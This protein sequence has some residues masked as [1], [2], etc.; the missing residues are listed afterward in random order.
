M[1]MSW[2]SWVVGRMPGAASSI[3]ARGVSARASRGRAGYG[4]I[5]LRRCATFSKEQR[6]TEGALSGAG[7]FRAKERGSGRPFR[8]GAVPNP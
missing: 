6:L 1:E 3:G 5:K 4:C 8:C 2:S 7:S